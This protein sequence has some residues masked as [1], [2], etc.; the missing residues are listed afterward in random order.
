MLLFINVYS[1]LVQQSFYCPGAP[2]FSIAQ[3]SEQMPHDALKRER[4]LHCLLGWGGGRMM[5]PESGVSSFYKSAGSA[6]SGESGSQNLR[7]L[8]WVLKPLELGPW[9]SPPS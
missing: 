9:L 4:F 5:A 2:P 1:D 6:S 3:L 8:H 7:R